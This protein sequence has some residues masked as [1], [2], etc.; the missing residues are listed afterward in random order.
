MYFASIKE[1]EIKGGNKA[2]L[3]DQLTKRQGYGEFLGTLDASGYHKNDPE[4][5]G[6][7]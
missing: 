7:R 5:L 2:N 4:E 6:E 3:Y 1:W